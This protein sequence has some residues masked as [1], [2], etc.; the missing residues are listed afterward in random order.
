M[1]QGQRDIASPLNASLILKVLVSVG[2]WNLK[3]NGGNDLRSFVNIGIG[4]NMVHAWFLLDARRIRNVV[5]GW[6]PSVE[7]LKEGKESMMTKERNRLL[8]EIGFLW[9]LRESKCLT[10]LWIWPWFILRPELG[11]TWQVLGP[12]FHPCIKWYLPFPSSCICLPRTWKSLDEPHERVDEVQDKAWAFWCAI[13]PPGNP[14]LAYWVENLRTQ[15]PRIQKGHRSKMLTK[16][17]LEELDAI[18]FTW[19]SKMNG[20]NSS[21][22]LTS[23]TSTPTASASTTN[24][25]IM[26]S[27]TCFVICSS[28]SRCA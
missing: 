24:S 6:C 7:L 11:C 10:I 22:L 26:Q 21:V 17:L 20:P 4:I 23:H 15:Y 16:K 14:E 3:L 1:F 19:E 5:D 18:G 27:P 9:I 12:H 28:E 2:K 13:H 8:Y 25:N